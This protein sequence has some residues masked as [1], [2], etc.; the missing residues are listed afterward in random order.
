MNKF[1]D[2]N[3]KNVNIDALLK[4]TDE[5][6]KKNKKKYEEES[7]IFRMEDTDKNGNSIAEDK[8]EFEL[9]TIKSKGK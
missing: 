7:I 3:W 9:V 8:C 1:S 6:I 2:I 4:E 5:W